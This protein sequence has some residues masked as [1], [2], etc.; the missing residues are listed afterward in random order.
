VPDVPD[1]A[2]PADAPPERLTSS[3]PSAASDRDETAAGSARSLW[4]AAHFG[5]AAAPGEVGTLG[6]YRIQKE[7]GRGGMGAVYLATDTRLERRVALKVMLPEFAANPEARERFLREARAASKVMHDNVVT[8]FE[9]DARDGVPYIAMQFL[10]GVP[11]DQFL[12]KKGT[13]PLRHVIR[14]AREAAQGLAAAHKTGLV[15]RDIKPANLWLEAPQGRVKI[16]DFGLARPVDADKEL[17]RSG[18]VVGTPAYMA[19]EQAR[20]Q[21]VDSRTDLFSL[22]AVMYQLCTGDIPFQGPTAMA[23]LLAL[24][25]EEPTPVRERNP[26]VPE[27][28]AALIH[29][30]L[31][32][33][34]ARRPQTADEVARLLRGATEGFGAHATAPSGSLPQ[35]V[36]VAVPVLTRGHAPDPATEFATGPSLIPRRKRSASRSKRP[37]LIGA[38][39]LVLA[40]L[41]A[42]V[43]LTARER[44]GNVVIELSEPEAKVEVRVD[45]GTVDAVG[46]GKPVKLAAGEHG[47][48]V[49]GPEYETV[50]Q[51]FAVGA[52]E[53]R[54]VRVA[55]KPV[56]KATSTGKVSPAPSTGPPFAAPTTA[57]SWRPLITSAADLEPA[58][59]TL[60]WS[61][62][63]TSTFSDGTLTLRGLI[64]YRGAVSGR[65]C[66]VRARVV[67]ESGE[68]IALNVRC[69]PGRASGYSFYFA[70]TRDKRVGHFGAGR[71]AGGKFTDL[72]VSFD[73]PLD[74]DR[75]CEM[76]LAAQGKKLSGYVNGKLSF[77]V[78]DSTQVEGAQGAGACRA[79]GRFRNLEVYV[80]DGTGLSPAE[81]LKLPPAVP[82]TA[83]R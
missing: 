13:P 15:H 71:H 41:A 42:V 45:G 28:L 57:G 6:P 78:E 67:L 11:L 59:R 19:P 43:A 31:A 80:L 46:P 32:K 14:I 16:L 66:V 69:Q 33:D 70:S 74:A 8:V 50:T 37:A 17:T 34:P 53:T 12:R 40:V 22:G 24:A 5:P 49:S 36:A 83:P 58:G 1:P 61:P 7:L 18:A 64:E 27:P 25:T 73:T 44:H 2:Q 75:S 51:S 3:T 29:S 21:K 54:V 60:F 62:N 38:G 10:Q 79:G 63:Q 55:L 26:E 9:A 47:L 56:A 65:D 30:L 23:V 48:S 20:G 76:A 77:L 52:G 4:A 35:L 72:I 68:N 82:V 81:V 39:V